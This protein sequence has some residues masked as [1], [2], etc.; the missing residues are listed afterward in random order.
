LNALIL[1]SIL[2]ACGTVEIQSEP[3]DAEIFAI[4]QGQDKGEPL[5]STPYKANLSDLSKIVGSGPILLQIRKNGYQTQSVIVPDIPGSQL[6]I[7]TDLKSSTT[8]THR[9][10]NRTVRLALR[11]E[12]EIL[13]KRLDAALATAKEIRQINEN[14][15]SAYEI[16]GA[17]RMLQG[18][19][20]KS[21]ESWERSLAIDPEN[22]DARAMIQLLKEKLG[23]PSSSKK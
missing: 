10:I 12:R 13:E 9:D 4:T 11:A 15:A 18:D 19:V 22:T 6:K 7:S 23:T 2:C 21:L 8:E 14:A 16:E 20:S 17:V 1:G 3:R 5:G